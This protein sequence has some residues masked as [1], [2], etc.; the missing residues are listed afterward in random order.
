MMKV[1]CF[2]E[3]MIRIQPADYYRFVQVDS[4]TTTFGGGE[5]NVSVSLAHYGLD[6]FYV[7]KLPEHEIGQAAINSLRRYGVNTEYIVRGGQRIG[8]YYNEKGASQRASKCIYDRQG[9]SIQTANPSEFNW[10]KILDGAKWF[11]ITGITP[12]LGENMLTACIEACK[13]A[14]QMGVTVSCD[15]NYRAKLWTKTEAQKAM[16]EICK[17]VDVCISNEDDAFDV[18]GIKAQNSDT[19]KGILD[20]ESYKSVAKQL[21]EKFPNFKKVAITLRSSVN[22]NRND[23]QALLF[24][25]EKYYFSKKY[26]LWIVDRVGGGDAFAAGLIYSLLQGMECQKAVDWAVSA[27]ALKHS[28]I[29]DF[30]MVS[31]SEVE[32]LASGDGSGR[33]QR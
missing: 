24:D 4:M 21:K 25:G 26:E 6:S 32:K 7:T 13:T 30:N 20:E 16:S 27:S 12:A 14:Q 2:G 1:V 31:V 23:W 18:F 33:I 28:I 8:I 9:S 5:A 17:Y 15:L 10:E 22:A 3:L 11:H 19:K 29:G